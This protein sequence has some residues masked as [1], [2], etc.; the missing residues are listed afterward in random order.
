M[1]SEE[2]LIERKL[3]IGGSDAAAVCGLSPWVTPLQLY[4]DKTSIEIDTSLNDKDFIKLGNMLEPT[5]VS[6]YEEKTGKTCYEDKRA[7]TH[8]KHK[9]MRANIDRRI[10]GEDNII[11]ECKTTG[12]FSSK[13]WGEEGTDQIPFNYVLQCAHY[14]AVLDIDQVD[15]A[16]LIGG[17]TFKCFKYK[18]NMKL[19]KSLIER[20]SYFWHE[21]VLK[22]NAPA[23]K[24]YED[25]LLKHV[26]TDESLAIADND[27]YELHSKL[28]D[29]N[30]N[31]KLLDKE[32]N[33]IKAKIC[34]HMGSSEKLID[35]DQSILATWKNVTTNRLDLTKFKSE[36]EEVYKKYLVKSSFRKF[37]LK[38]I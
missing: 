15:I 19:E 5:V 38:G 7:F 32:K 9:W 3:G 27:I 2:Q 37:N 31:I 6:L 30:K 11:L 18:R 35:T 23:S 17:Q 1:L 26:K 28:G 13:K 8:K 29:I 4:N 33:V 34:E 14:A 20:E 24:T 10:K 36:Q 16:V 21:N 12:A 22:K 25:A